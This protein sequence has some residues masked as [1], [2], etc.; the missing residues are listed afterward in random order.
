M[1]NITLDIKTAISKNV[2]WRTN[3]F[4]NALERLENKNYEISF[5]EGDENW[6]TV[7]VNNKVI[8]Y[9]WQKYPLG[10]V[11]SEYMSIMENLLQSYGFVTLIETSN[12]EKKIFKIDYEELKNEI[13]YGLN[14][15]RF[16]VE[17]LWFYTNSI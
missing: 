12:F 11:N 4:F 2:L 16:S 14:S 3:E 9:L 1:K 10:F 5:W 8:A 13:D 15:D 17:D 6:A 7:L